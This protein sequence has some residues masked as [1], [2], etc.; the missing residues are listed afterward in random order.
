M[1][2]LRWINE[3]HGQLAY[4][5]GRWDELAKLAENELAAME[6]IGA[7]YLEGSWH[8]LR[9]LIR[10][11]RGDRDG[12]RAELEA[13]L[14]SAHQVNEPQMLAADPRATPAHDRRA[15]RPRSR[16]ASS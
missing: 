11:A 9:S 14:A 7:H 12:V 2:W 4:L 3:K 5:T 16:R 13:Q 10:L 1:E 6:S 8:S 15:R